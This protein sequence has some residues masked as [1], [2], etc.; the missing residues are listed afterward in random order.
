M[1]LLAKLHIESLA[2]K[3]T[4]KAVREA[5][6]RLPADLDRTYDEAMERIDHQSVD[7]RELAHLVLTWVA[8]TL[9][10]LSVAELCEAL[11][12]EPHTTAL[13]PDNLLDIEIVTSVCAGLIIVDEA[14][15]VVRLI[16]FTTQAYFNKIQSIRFPHAHKTIASAC[17]TYLSFTEFSNI[18]HWKCETNFSLAELSN[19]RGPSD[20][21][22]KIVSE[23][24]ITWL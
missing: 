16:H 2:T 8:N 22:W 15:S 10:P 17:L 9:N 14:M 1:F 23:T 3:N 21:S 18:P 6:K 12:I 13:D 5:L 4:V 20:D 19:Y 24:S 11:A 7:D